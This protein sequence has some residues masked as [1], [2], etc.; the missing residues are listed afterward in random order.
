MKGA[1]SYSSLEHAALHAMRRAIN[2]SK[3]VV[4]LRNQ[5]SYVVTDF[6]LEVFSDTGMTIRQDDITFNSRQPTLPFTVSSRLSQIPSF[7]ERWDNSDM[8]GIIRKFA[9]TTYHRYLHLER[10]QRKSQLKIR[11]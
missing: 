4:E 6:L 10:Q 2:N 1:P 8:S 3:D 5:F 9:D 11:N 7:S